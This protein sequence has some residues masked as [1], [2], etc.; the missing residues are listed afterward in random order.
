MNKGKTLDTLKK[1]IE[2]ISKEKEEGLRRVEDQGP[3][4][5]NLEPMAVTSAPGSTPETKDKEKSE[6]AEL[7]DAF[8]SWVLL[9]KSKP[10]PQ[11]LLGM[12]GCKS[13]K[14]R[15]YYDKKILSYR[16]NNHLGS[17]QL[18]SRETIYDELLDWESGEERSDYDPEEEESDYSQDEIVL[19]YYASLES[20]INGIGSPEE[21]KTAS[22]AEIKYSIPASVK[23]VV[24]KYR[25]LFSI[26]EFSHPMIKDAVFEKTLPEDAG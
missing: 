6:I 1:E 24:K 3:E 22:P 18:H 2:D 17:V 5:K 26:D 11:V 4:T 9:N 25:N 19:M 12:N 16:G 10:K 21:E 15:L 7:K 13:L 8:K 14:F 20:E 23:L